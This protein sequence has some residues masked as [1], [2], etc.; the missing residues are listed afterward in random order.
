VKKDKGTKETLI[1]VASV[2]PT[3]LIGILTLLTGNI[4]FF[5]AVIA[6]GV[7]DYFVFQWTDIEYE[8]LYLDKEI[9][10]DKI[11]AKTRRKKLTT[12]SVE[13]IEIMA[14][15]KSYQLDSYRNRQ[16]KVTDLSAGHDLPDQKLYW[17]FYEGNQ[18]ILMN[19]TE[20]FAK[21]IKGIAPRKVFTD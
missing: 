20:D 14:P 1:R 21:T 16:T 2:V 9:S 12:I 10:V 6:F 7:L 18:K 17:V 15:E 4:V 3:V 11:M 19:L 5:I 8:Y 13:K